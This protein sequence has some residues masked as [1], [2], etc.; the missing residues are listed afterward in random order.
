MRKKILAIATLVVMLNP[1]QVMAATT[2]KEDKNAVNN[3]AEY[4]SKESGG[5][6]EATSTVESPLPDSVPEPYRSSFTLAANNYN[7]QPALLAALFYYGEHAEHWPPARGDLPGGGWASSNIGYIWP[8]G[9]QSARGPFQ[10]IYPTWAGLERTKIGDFEKDPDKIKD[11]AYRAANYAKTNGVNK[12]SDEATVRRFIFSYNHAEW[13]VNKVYNGYKLFLRGQGGGDSSPSP[14][15][16]VT[17]E[18]DCSSASSSNAGENGWDITGPHKMVVYNQNDPKWADKPYG[19]GKSAIAASG[20][21]PTAVAMV[22]ATLTNNPSITPLRIA[23]RYGDSYHVSEGSKWDLFIDAPRHY[24]LKSRS[25]GTNF[26]EAAK[27]LRAGGLV[28]ISVHAGE[29]T[30]GGHI[31]VVRAV[32]EDGQKFYLADPNDNSSKK[33]NEKGYEKDFLLGQMNNMWAI[34]K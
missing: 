12:T 32:S 3:T 26:E 15:P 20:C 33:H 23:N 24:D 8:D 9:K 29:F 28:I 11:S 22:I 5:I 21:G 4:F 1:Y 13:Y 7:I 19:E 30:S 17:S 18:E 2:S 27:A 16:T 10:F 6:C 14:D 34:T 31:M 25:I